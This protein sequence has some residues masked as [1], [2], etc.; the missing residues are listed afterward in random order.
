MVVPLR[1]EVE[2]VPYPY[3]P[4]RLHWFHSVL[5]EAADQ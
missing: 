5:E 2:G 4:W 1:P 3:Q